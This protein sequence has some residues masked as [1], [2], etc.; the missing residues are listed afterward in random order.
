MLSRCRSNCCF[1][2]DEA[3]GGLSRSS[4]TEHHTSSNLVARRFPPPLPKKNGS[5]P[6]WNPPTGLASATIRDA[7]SQSGMNPPRS[8]TSLLGV[9]KRRSLS[10]KNRAYLRR[11][12]EAHFSLKL[13]SWKS[14]TAPS[15]KPTPDDLK[16][17]IRSAIP[18]Q[19]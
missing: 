1:N 9:V 14:V 4:R 12:P 5:I 10:T 17:F 18:R 13:K 8:T 15:F 7:V 2:M 16:G 3:V 11:L 6:P 19:G